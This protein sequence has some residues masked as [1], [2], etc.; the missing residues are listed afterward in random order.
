[1]SDLPK[2]YFIHAADASQ[3]V[4]TLE[5]ILKN[6]KEEHR[7]ADAVRLKETPWT[8]PE[9]LLQPK[10]MV[11]LLLTEGL[12]P[13]V[14]GIEEDLGKAGPGLPDLRMMEIL[15][16]NVPYNNNLL[17]FPRDTEPIRGR[18]DM[19]AEWKDIGANLREFYP[20]TASPGKLKINKKWI[21]TGAAVIVAAVVF[22][23]LR[24]KAKF[25]YEVRDQITGIDYKPKREGYTPCFV[26]IFDESEKSD[27][28]RIEIVDP[29]GESKYDVERGAKYYLT[30]L[31]RPGWNKIVITASSFLGTSTFTDSIWVEP[32]PVIDFEVEK[33]GCHAPCEMNFKAVQLPEELSKKPFRKYEWYFAGAKNGERKEG[34]NPRGIAFEKNKIYENKTFDVILTATNDD[35]LSA[36][37][38]KKVM[39]TPDGSPFPKFSVNQVA[40]DDKTGM[41]TLKFENNSLSST[42]YKWLYSRE[43]YPVVKDYEFTTTGEKSFNRVFKKGTYH[44]RLI[45]ENREGEHLPI[46]SEIKELVIPQPTRMFLSPEV[47]RAILTTDLSSKIYNVPPRDCTA[48]ARPNLKSEMIRLEKK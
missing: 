1:M 29:V 41:G 38:Q 18:E 5:A 30:Q 13:L 25:V 8:L 39:V 4:A 12:S 42:H 6:L 36:K 11:I 37:A 40:Y 27:S 23:L 33:D 35:G 7:I 46:E 32:A 17:V 26:Q 14:E 15:V 21:Y 3:H 19:D 34:A 31:T 45:A 43:D 28:V 47:L 10:D 16:D 9:G 24:P 22:F 20:V 2:I 48:V 44:F